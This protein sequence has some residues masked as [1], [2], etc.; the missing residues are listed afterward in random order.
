MN[1]TSESPTFSLVFLTWNAE[2]CISDTLDSVANQTYDDYEVVVVDNASDDETVNIVNEYMDELSI[3]LLENDRNLGFSEGTNRGIRASSGDYICCYNHDTYFPPDY[4]KIVVDHVT[5]D[6]VWTTARENHRVSTGQRTVRLLGRQRY[7]I[8]YA[9]DSLSGT[10][11]VN[12]VPGDGVIIPKK[13]YR[14]CIE[15][16]VFRLDGRGE[17]VEFSLRMMSKGVHLNTILDT[18][19]VHPDTGIYEPTFENFVEH[20]RH[21]YFRGQAY[22][23]NNRSLF[24][25][26]MV[27]LSV[28]TV[29]LTIYFEE[30]PRD[31]DTFARRTET[32]KKIR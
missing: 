27:A 31:A 12:F 13:V 26:L 5:H 25:I 32:L 11:A 2:D 28:F 22:Y 14:E 6:A 1:T 3:R 4:L 15:N 19:S 17:D 9:V 20:L 8:P 24:D 23:R 21:A 7:A 18:Y 10:E 30:L 16:E 29:P